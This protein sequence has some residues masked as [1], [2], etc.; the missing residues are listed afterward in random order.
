MSSMS[1]GE[2]L[3]LLNEMIYKATKKGKTRKRLALILAREGYNEDFRTHQYGTCITCG[4]RHFCRMAPKGVS[5]VR[6]N[7]PHYIGPMKVDPWRE[8]GAH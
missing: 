6:I 1:R 3:I 4:K 7:C 8:G 2:V 5:G